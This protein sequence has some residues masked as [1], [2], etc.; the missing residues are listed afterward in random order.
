[1]LRVKVRDIDEVGEVID[2][3][4]EAGG[5]LLR[6]NRISFGIEDSTVL[7][8]EA[9]EEAMADAYAKAEQMAALAGVRLGKLIYMTDSPATSYRPSYNNWEMSTR[10]LLDAGDFTPTEISSGGLDV[11]VNVHIKYAIG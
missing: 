11:V 2:D 10:L 4:V 7:Y 6:V 1:M 9:R 3:A 8:D 5:D